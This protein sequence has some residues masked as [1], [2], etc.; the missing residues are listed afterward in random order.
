MQII[1]TI[2]DTPTISIGGIILGIISGLISGIFGGGGGFL[3]TPALNIFLGIPYNIAIG[4]SSFQVLGS[5]SFS[6]YHQFD[7]K[8][9]GVK[10]AFLTGIGIPVGSVLGVKLVGRFGNLGTIAFAGHITPAQQLI[11][12]SIF[13]AFLGLIAS[14]LLFDNFYLRRGREHDHHTGYLAWIKIKPMVSCETIPNGPFSAPVFT[15]IGLFVGFLGGLLG[16]GGG[17]I[18]MPLLFYVVGQETKYAARTSNMLAFMTSLLATTMH[19]Y[20]GNI[21][22]LLVIFLLSGAF[23]GA[24]LGAVIQ[25]RIVGKTIRKYF[26]FVVLSAVIMVLIKLF[27]IIKNAPLA[28]N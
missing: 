19:A 26:A 7:R 11:F 10:I 18:M 3:I 9:H 6:L 8:M 15:I 12:T 28:T 1:Q 16:I 23:I 17:V 20:K 13:C 4:T 14:W 25:R 22:Y 21:N 5:T 24:R 27:F 2:I